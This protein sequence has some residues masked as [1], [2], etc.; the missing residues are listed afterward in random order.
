MALHRLDAA[1]GE[2]HELPHRRRQVR[3]AA[4]DERE[5][6]VERRI[7]RDAVEPR[8]PARAQQLARAQRVAEAAGGELQRGG[9][10]LDLDLR[11]E[12]HPGRLRALAQLAAHRVVGAP[13]RVVEDQRRVGESLD[14]HRRAQAFGIDAD[15]EHFLAHR[16]PDVEAAVVDRQ[17][18]EAG[19]D[20][21]VADLV[22]D[23]G[24]VLADR[25]HAHVR[26]LLAEVLDQADQ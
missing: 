5:V 6:V 25:P 15:V 23:L 1:L 24:R 7:E 12:L 10:V 26:M 18:D 8:Q 20:V 17:C 9:D 13:A 21:A 19:L 22:R 3:V 16:G 4:R 2:A 11:L 14:R